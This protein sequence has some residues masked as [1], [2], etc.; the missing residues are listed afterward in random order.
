MGQRA[1]RRH[2]LAS[3]RIKQVNLATPHHASFFRSSDYTFALNPP[4][5]STTRAAESL[6]KTGGWRNRRRRFQRRGRNTDEIL[7]G[8]RFQKKS[9]QTGKPVDH[10]AGWDVTRERDT[11]HRRYQGH[12]LRGQGGVAKVHREPFAAGRLQV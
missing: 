8:R 12:L 7:R 2:G 5:A 4:W 9:W 11:D 3:A 6:N 1:R 10:E